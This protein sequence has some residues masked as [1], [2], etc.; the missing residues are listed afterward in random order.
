VQLVDDHRRGV[1]PVRDEAV[2]GDRAQDAAVSRVAD[3][4]PSDLED[5]EKRP[6]FDKAAGILEDDPRL[7]AGSSGEDHV[8]LVRAGDELLK[9]QPRRERRLAVSPRDPE[10]AALVDALPFSAYTRE[11]LHKALLPRLELEWLPGSRTLHVG[12][13]CREEPR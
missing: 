11:L 6:R 10:H 7:I 5:V 13:H 4:V 2:R 1:E 8:R 3:L 9:R 12:E